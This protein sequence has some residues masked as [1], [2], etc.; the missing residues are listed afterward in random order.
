MHSHV[1]TKPTFKADKL[2]AVVIRIAGNGAFDA[3]ADALPGIAGGKFGAFP[4][5]SRL[6]AAAF[7]V[8]AE[9]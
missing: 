8:A 6:T 1:F 4:L 3:I 5:K 2:F 7:P 9:I